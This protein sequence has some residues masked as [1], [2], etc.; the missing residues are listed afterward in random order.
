MV[1]ARRR[2]RPAR[3]RAPRAERPG[4]R[5]DFVARQALPL[6]NV[7][8]E[9]QFEVRNIFGQ[10]YRELQEFGDNVISINS[11]DVGTSVSLGLNVRF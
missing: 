2:C 5:V 10:D 6:G 8:G 7:E 4:L 1:P 3:D 11:Y 9:L